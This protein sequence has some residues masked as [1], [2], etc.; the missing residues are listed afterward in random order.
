MDK[1]ENIGIVGAGTMGH[2]IAQVAVQSGFSVMLVDIFPEV[3]D[4]ALGRIES[5]LTRA[6][7][8]GRISETDLARAR[9]NLSTS[10]DLESLVGADLVIEA[11][12]E[13]FDVK[14]QV[15]V[16]LD[17][18]VPTTTIL[19]TN[20]SSIS[21]TRLAAATKRP[22]KIIGMH[23][24]NPV[25]VMR[26]IEIIR[27]LATSQETYERVEEVSRQMNKTPVEVHDA[28]G[29]VSNRVLMPM[30]NEAVFCLH[31]GVGT[32]RAIDQVMQL[33]MNQP[34]GPLSLA[35]LIGLDVCMDILDVLYEGFRDSKYR[36][37]P[38]LAKMVDAGYLGKK[39]GRGFYTYEGDPQLTFNPSE[40]YQ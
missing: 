6:R 22:E 28:P 13:R 3:L 19:A 1:I 11:V 2:G 23:F 32:V 14:R 29:F 10:S 30:I 5:G 16:E 35:D 8:K 25:P 27:G 39:A 17:A 40:G 20:T 36:A 18:L 7:D 4:S 31:E 37:C 26:L 9:E 15:L 21:I 24:M 34:M 38:L 12:V 33:G